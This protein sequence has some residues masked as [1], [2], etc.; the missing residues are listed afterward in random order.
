MRCMVINLPLSHERRE[1]IGHEFE[2]VGLDHE[3]WPA[4]SR[5]ELTDEHRALVDHEGRS[6]RGMVEMDDAT[7]G[8]LASHLSL[9]RHFLETGD[10]MIAVFEDDARL[11]PDIVDVLDALERGGGGGGGGG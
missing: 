5:F 6:R 1:G 11:H 9:L 3:L 10:D 4:V 7:I 2:R 8:C